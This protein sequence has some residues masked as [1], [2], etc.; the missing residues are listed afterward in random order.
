[1][2]KDIFFSGFVGMFITSICYELS[3]PKKA[4]S[5]QNRFISLVSAVGTILLRNNGKCFKR[6]SASKDGVL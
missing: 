4:S 2:S 1:M 5:S 3:L 6:V